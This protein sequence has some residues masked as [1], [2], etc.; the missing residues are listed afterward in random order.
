MS[1]RI[2]SFASSLVAFV[3]AGAAAAAPAARAADGDLDSTFRS[4]GKMTYITAAGRVAA[5]ALDDQGRPLISYTRQLSGTDRDF[6]YL[7]ILDNG[8]ILAAASASTSVAPTTTRSMR[9]Q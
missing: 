7:H 5:V 9:W 1:N 2:D 6:A 4:G 3:L 8:V